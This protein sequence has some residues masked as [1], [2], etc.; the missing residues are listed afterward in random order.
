MPC[1]DVKVYLQ[2]KEKILAGK[3]AKEIKEIQELQ[4]RQLNYCRKE[5]KQRADKAERWRRL[6]IIL[7]KKAG[8]DMKVCVCVSGTTTV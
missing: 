5:R 1:P 3:Q 8:N 4:A 2:A 6:G 7:Q